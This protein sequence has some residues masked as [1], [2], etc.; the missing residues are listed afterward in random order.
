MDLISDAIDIH[1]HLIGLFAKKFAGKVGNHRARGSKAA[2]L[3]TTATVARLV[4]FVEAN[5]RSSEFDRQ[6]G[7]ELDG[8]PLFKRRGVEITGSITLIEI[9][10]GSLRTRRRCYGLGVR[11]RNSFPGS[12][13]QPLQDV[14]ND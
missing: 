3:A 10:H 12:V 2:N 13:L 4:F 1:D 5:Q 7:I 14:A 8:E 9:L 11:R 6:A